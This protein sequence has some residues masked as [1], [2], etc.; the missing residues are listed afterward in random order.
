ME[1]HLVISLGESYY[2][3]LAKGP[4]VEDQVLILPVEHSPN[5]LSLPS[6]SETEL[7]RFQ[8]SLKMYFKTQ[9][10]EVVFFEWIFKRGTHANIQVKEICFMC[11]LQVFN[12]LIATFCLKFIEL[13]AS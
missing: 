7:V 3:A 13:L 6:E 10:K 9:V 11:L 8:K 1:S 12:E 5:T 4:L 2:C